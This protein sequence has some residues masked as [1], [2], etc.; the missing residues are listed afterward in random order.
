MT[1]DSQ[2]DKIHQ[3]VFYYRHKNEPKGGFMMHRLHTQPKVVGVKQ[4]LRAIQKEMVDV[5]Y[6]AEDAQSHVT[7]KVIESAKERQIPMVMVD[8]MKKLG[9]F[10]Q[11]EVQTATAAIVKKEKEV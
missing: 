9:E 7:Q 10:C 5:V 6:I 11:V 3:C 4:T 8:T 2:S 1:N